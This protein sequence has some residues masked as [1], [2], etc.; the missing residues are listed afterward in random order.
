MDTDPFPGADPS[1][2]HRQTE[3]AHWSRNWPGIQPPMYAPSGF[4]PPPS[5]HCGGGVLP[6]L[7]WIQ[8]YPGPWCRSRYH[9]LHSH[10]FS[11]NRPPSSSSSCRRSASR[12]VEPYHNEHSS[13]RPW[14]TKIHN[15]CPFKKTNPHGSLFVLGDPP[16]GGCPVGCPLKPP[17]LGYLKKLI[18]S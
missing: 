4:I 2:L 3:P 7:S 1:D 13:A 10:A 18:P 16:N 11:R 17:K 12:I 8:T 15:P 14:T 6:C 5:I 9:L